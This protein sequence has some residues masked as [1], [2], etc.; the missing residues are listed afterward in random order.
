MGSPNCSAD[1]RT[2]VSI[3]RGKEKKEEKE[4]ESDWVF[5][6]F[7]LPSFLPSLLVFPC[8]VSSP[9][10]SDLTFTRLLSWISSVSLSGTWTSCR[11]GRIE[12]WARAYPL[13]KLPDFTHIMM[14]D[15]K[16]Q[17]QR[18]EQQQQQQQQPRGLPTEESHNELHQSVKNLMGLRGETP[19]GS[20]DTSSPAATP[21]STIAA[22]A[23]AT[24]AGHFQGN[25]SLQHLSNTLD[26]SFHVIGVG[27]Q[28]PFPPFD[29]GY[30]EIYSDI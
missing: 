13:D 3:E 21:G 16:P 1:K 20:P 25:Q 28:H 17:Q 27:W 4:G 14:G 18:H 24:Y 7:F 12:S 9:R 11:E 23:A 10:R 26:I 6:P 30:H 5:P 2:G 15:R 29:V 8:W 19:G 22:Y